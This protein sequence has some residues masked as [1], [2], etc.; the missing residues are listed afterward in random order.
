MRRVVEL[1]RVSTESQAG[2]DRASIPSQREINHRTAMLHGLTIVRSVEIADV[3][4]T[5]V[6]K[7]PEMI[8]LLEFIKD[9]E[10]H[11]V[12]AREFSRLMRPED[13]SDYYILQVFAE[14]NTLLYLDGSPPID[15][16]S[17]MGRVFG[18]MQAAFAG[19]QRVEFLESGW[20]SKELKRK[21]GE[22]PQSHICLP[23][24]VRYE[25]S[26]GKDGW[27]WTVESE[28]VKEAFRLLLAGVESYSEIGRRVGID[29]YSLRVMLR[30]PI[31]TGWRVY[32]KRRDP[33]A[34]GKYLTRDG[35]QG[36][37]RKILRAPEDVIRVQVL[38]PLVSERSFQ[39]A[40]Q[41]M[42]FKKARH[43]RTRETEHR[44]TYN[45]FLT[46]ALCQGTIYTKFRRRDY[47]VCK[48]K[49]GASY[50]RREKF[51]PVLDRLF[52]EELMS[53]KRISQ[54]I[55]GLR[56]QA[57]RRNTNRLVAQLNSL[58]GKRQRILDSYFDGVI[59]GAERESRMTQIERERNMLQDLLA[60]EEPSEL[61]T[62][63]LTRMF[64]PLAGFANLNR[65]AKR[66]ILAG[67]TA[68]VVAAD[69]KVAGLWIGQDLNHRGKGSSPPPT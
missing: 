2:K 56:K 69:Y 47:Y 36:E 45:G 22:F 38:D 18:V 63:T 50:M 25:R 32:D 37:R 10:I 61:S 68:G 55:Q 27:E 6:L 20:N 24:G 57:P 26:R 3:S 31:Y 52:A 58:D 39:R 46:C 23:F 64:R 19:A 13:Y 21:A 43:W 14:T 51:E 35:R 62:E 29:P 66:K 28:R 41:I 54:I 4:G 30:N 12:V 53:V 9:S 17:K 33:S 59:S 60:R 65:D 40:Q 15:F 34:S 42:D 67:M 8:G 16:S 49:C 5:A 11:G 1:I 7:S 44:F 48:G